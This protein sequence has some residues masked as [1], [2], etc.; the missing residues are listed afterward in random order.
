LRDHFLSHP[1][2]GLQMS[3]HSK[4]PV[5]SY[6]GGGRE[7]QGGG[8]AG[9]GSDA[10]EADTAPASSESAGSGASGA[11][12]AIDDGR[13]RRAGSGGSGSVGASVPLPPD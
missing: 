5:E 2:R 11:S 7:T 13:E 8:P 9:R 10:D 3:E 12:S 4:E 6:G 1:A